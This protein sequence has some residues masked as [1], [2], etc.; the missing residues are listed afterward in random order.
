MRDLT[1]NTKA[2][3]VRTCL[4][5]LHVRKI[6]LK[7]FVSRN[8]TEKSGEGVRKSHGHH[9]LEEALPPTVLTEDVSFP[10]WGELTPASL[11]GLCILYRLMKCQPN[12]ELSPQPPAL[13]AWASFPPSP[14][15]GVGQILPSLLCPQDPFLSLA[16]PCLNILEHC[17]SQS[18]LLRL[19]LP[20][21]IPQAQLLPPSLLG[22]D[23]KIAENS[24]PR[25]V[26]RALS[27]FET[28]AG[29][30][31]LSLAAGEPCPPPLLSNCLAPFLYIFTYLVGCMHPQCSKWE[32]SPPTRDGTWAPCIG[33]LIHW[34]TREEPS[35]SLSAHL[36]LVAV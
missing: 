6:D 9:W 13:S 17:P 12:P 25:P 21:P 11:L 28:P 7:D 35:S 3:S 18:L 15:P 19:H 23:Q 8:S 24:Q 1:L 27:S 4:P 31:M 34:T 20:N 5:S 26:L 36:V 30:K 32:S 33:S 16:A 14:L 22:R 10:P 2:R 29:L